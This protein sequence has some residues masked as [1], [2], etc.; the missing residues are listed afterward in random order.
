MTR[1]LI[2]VDTYIRQQDRDRDRWAVEREAWEELQPVRPRDPQ[3]RYKPTHP[4]PSAD[5]A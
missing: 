2:P 4:R 5:D 3:G 1:D